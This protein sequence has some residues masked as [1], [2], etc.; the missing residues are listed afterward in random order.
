MFCSRCGRSL[1]EGAAFC[2]SCGAPAPSS[3]AAASAPAPEAGFAS[4]PEP[5]SPPP[6]EP[7]PVPVHAAAPPP[8]AQA[9]YVGY[10]GFWRRVLAAIIDGLIM[11]LAMLPFGLGMGFAD[12]GLMREDPSSIFARLAAMMFVCF[13]R[14]ILS[15]VYGAGFESSPWQAT[16]GKMVLGLKVT[17]LEGRRIGFARATG[18]NLAKV[19]SSLILCIGYLMVAFTEKKQ[20]LHDMLAGTLVRR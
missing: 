18:R 15:W 12:L 5:V 9:T 14:L 16:P 6:L 2:P 13:V 17:D 8:V 20:G 7:T 11:G 4:G 10:G 3:S 19:L 1:P